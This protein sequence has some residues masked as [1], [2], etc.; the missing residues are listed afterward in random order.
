MA[1]IYSYPLAEEVTTDSW[2][3]GSEM[4]NG[5]R[6]VKNY[7]VG[8]IA[9][10]IESQ[11]TT[12]PTLQ[13]VTAEGANTTIQMQINGVDV[14]TVNDIPAAPTL[15]Q[16]TDEGSDSYGNIINLKK[17][18]NSDSL[19]QFNV[20]SFFEPYIKI[21][22]A[23][24]GSGG[25]YMRL[26][27]STIEFNGDEDYNTIIEVGTGLNNTV[28]LPSESGTLALIDDIPTPPY[29]V[30]TA[31]I[32]QNGTTAPFVIEVLEN[33]LSG[34]V[35]FEYTNPGLYYAVLAGEFGSNRT[36]AMLWGGTSSQLFKAA[37]VSFDNILLVTYDTSGVPANNQM[38]VTTL[39]IRVYNE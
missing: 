14:A 37:R 29:R 8:D 15:Q 9:A 13:D 20:G 38:G 33:T 32:N 30:Y 23:G 34:P 36:T 19:I 21:E 26:G 5:V 25:H 24:E 28:A 17:E 35:T 16:V 39:E 6:V 31:L 12:A 2:V 18:S 3:L 10:F 1:I 22:N 11:F 7:S 27:S 4:D